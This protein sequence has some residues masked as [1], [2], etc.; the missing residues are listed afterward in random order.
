M[1]QLTFYIYK[2]LKLLQQLTENRSK[3][4]QSGHPIPGFQANVKAIVC[5]FN[6]E[7][8]LVGAFSMIVKTLLRFVSISSHPQSTISWSNARR[9]Q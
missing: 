7:M 2:I 3:Y 6:K 8:A 1:T 5:T 9:V 4:K